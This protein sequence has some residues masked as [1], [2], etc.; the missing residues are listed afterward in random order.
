MNLNPRLYAKKTSERIKKQGGPFDRRRKKRRREGQAGPV[1]LKEI[2]R[3]YARV[4]AMIRS[5]NDSM[6]DGARC[7]IYSRKKCIFSASACIAWILMGGVM[8]SRASPPR[9]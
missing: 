7:E 4:L 9:F 5:Q 8:Q 6:L 1:L 3:G 2:P